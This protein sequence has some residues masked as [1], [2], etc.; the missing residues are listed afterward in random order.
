MSGLAGTDSSSSSESEIDAGSSSFSALKALYSPNMGL[1]PEA[2]V[3]DNVDKFVSVCMEKQQGNNKK[4]QA[5][6]ETVPPMT[7]S[8]LP[9]QM[10]VPGKSKNLPNLLKAMS[11]FAEAGGPLSLLSKCVGEAKRVR[12]VTRGVRGLRGHCTGVPVAFD[13]HWNLALVDVDE[14]FVRK[15]RRKCPVAPETRSQWVGEEEE[16]VGSS[17]V[18]VVLRRRNTEVCE[19]HVTQVVLRGEHVALVSVENP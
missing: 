1:D 5:K 6:E 3:F 17:V 16:R 18:R 7:R 8:F 19:R 9:S 13:K 15:R 14:R 11:R 10:P 2:P 12:V 4:K